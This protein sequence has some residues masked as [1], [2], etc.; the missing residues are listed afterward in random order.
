M[1]TEITD[2][3]ACYGASTT[4]AVQ[5]GA[6][7]SWRIGREWL[8]LVDAHLGVLAGQSSAMAGTVDWPTVVSFTGF[9]RVQWRYH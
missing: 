1:C 7:V 8:L 3:L 5:A 6:L 9:A 4:T 2:V